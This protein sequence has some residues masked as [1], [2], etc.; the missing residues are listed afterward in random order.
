MI[1]LFDSGYGGLTIYKEVA[2]AL[3]QYDYLYLGDN[4]RAPYGN[5]SRETVTEYTDTAVRY[6]FEAGA[7]LIII[8]C[9]TASAQA[10]RALQQKYLRDNASPYRDRKILGVIRPVV[11][12]A[13][14]LTK[15]GR[16]SVIGTRST[17]SSKAFE[18]E[19]K[20]EN[21]DITVSQQACPLL[22]PLI[23]EHWHHKP[24]AHKILRMYLK[25]LK[26]RSIASAASEGGRLLSCRNQAR[27]EGAT[28]GP[29]LDTLILGCTHYPHMLVD[30]RRMMGKRTMIV[31]PGPVVAES[32]KEYLQRH[33]DIETQL[34]Q[35]GTRKFL[36]TEDPARFKE[37]A[38]RFA[39]IELTVIKKTD[40]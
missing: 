7:R 5:R 37:F 15:T 10:L 31:N 8:A 26:T 29:I 12:K 14:R 9:F 32:L 34:T 6:L 24:V 27:Q 33:S 38:E 16:V 28:L 35:N 21:P 17:V 23:E 1:G 4:A 19:L 39:G 25:L 11:E 2:K 20:R 40:L 22:V 36:T 30:I 3:P 18:I 13:A